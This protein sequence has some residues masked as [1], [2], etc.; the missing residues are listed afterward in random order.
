MDT[1]TNLLTSKSA[2]FA[3]FIEASALLFAL[4]ISYSFPLTEAVF[5]IEP[6]LL[7]LQTIFKLTEAPLAKLP[8]F[9]TP[10]E[11]EPTEAADE[12]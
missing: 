5:L 2:A 1:L 4:L 12:R 6:V 7:T 10:L 3:T 9:Q 11:Y 8:I